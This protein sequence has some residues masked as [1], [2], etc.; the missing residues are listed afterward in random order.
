MRGRLINGPPERALEFLVQKAKRSE[1]FRWITPNMDHV[2]L[3]SQ[4]VLCRQYEAAE[5]ISIDGAPVACLLRLMGMKVRRAP[6]SDVAVLLIRKSPPGIR[7]AILAGWPGEESLYQEALGSA[8]RGR[9]FVICPP[10]LTEEADLAAWLLEAALPVLLRERCNLVLCGIGAPRS[11]LAGDI[12]V[13]S[14]YRGVWM[15]VGSGVRFALGFD[16]RA[17]KVLQRIGLE[18]LHRTIREPARMS[19]RYAQDFL[20]FFHRSAYSW[21]W[22]ISR[23]SVTSRQLE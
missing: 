17:P 16:E 10:R 15:N 6:G 22:R 19:C 11:E 13:A 14:G 3:L 5:G 2:R 18:W 1:P 4:G 8:W 9:S 23:L 20:C 12:I 21:L 7:L